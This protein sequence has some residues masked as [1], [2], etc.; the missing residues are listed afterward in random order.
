[1]DSMSLDKCIPANT[2]HMLQMSCARKSYVSSPSEGHIV[3]L[4]E[5][6]PPHCSFACFCLLLLQLAPHLA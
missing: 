4:A 3:Q 6:G 5:V 1:M 2:C